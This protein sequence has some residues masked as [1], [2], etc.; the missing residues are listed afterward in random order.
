MAV[1]TIA[2]IQHKLDKANSTRNHGGL[3]NGH[4]KIDPDTAR[5][6]YGINNT[7]RSRAIEQGQLIAAAMDHKC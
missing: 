1:L 7:F 3:N 6:P 5:L 4:L 2:G